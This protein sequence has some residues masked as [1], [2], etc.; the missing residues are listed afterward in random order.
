MNFLRVNMSSKKITT[1]EASEKYRLLGNRGLIAQLSF[2]EIDPKCDPLGPNNKL[3]IATS[4]LDGFGITCAGRL[5]V[6]GKSP[7]TGG[8]KEANAGGVA[9]TKLVR[10]GIKAIIVEG[11]SQN[12]EL[13]I[14]H[15]HKGG[16]QL[17]PAKVIAGKGTYSVAEKVYEEYGLGAGLI[18]I[19]PAGEYRLASAG[20]FINDTEGEPS[21][22]AARGGMGAVMGTK[23]LKAIV[24]EDDGTYKPPVFNEKALSEARKAFS[25]GIIEEPAIKVYTEYGTMG[26]LMSLNALSGLPT[27]NFRKGT[28]E[29]AEEI[30]GDRFHDLILERG[31]EGKI[32]HKCMPICVIQCSNVFPDANGKKL[33]APLEFEC[34]GLLGSNLGIADLDQIARLTKMCND[35]GVDAIEVGAALGVAADAGLFEFADGKRAEELIG[36]IG[37]GTPLGRILGSGATVTGKVF[38]VLRVPA[39]KGQ[40]M[41]AHDPRGIKGMS[42]TY[43]MSPMGADHT[44]AATYRAQIDHHKPEG[45]MEVSRNVQVIMAFYDNCCCMFVS[46][47]LIKKPELF[48]NLINAIYGTNYGTDYLMELGK[49][50]IKLERAFNLAAGVT[51]EYLPEFMKIEKLEPHGLTSDIPQSDYDRFWEEAFWG[52]FPELK[53]G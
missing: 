45:Q 37:R 4:P 9:A 35:I 51:Q 24:I 5:S 28:W 20:V 10:Q 15:I 31:G 27:L 32:T 52:K 47:G 39:V 40:A 42:V 13:Y 21:R 1:E 16:A 2:D 7:L 19:G 12:G 3:I 29:K 23:G 48:V 53:Q 25:K 11:M 49:E 36:E 14:L 18:T 43:S 6:G 26:M 38:G 22:P 17:E 41:A 34:A 46:R 30:S 50:I 44:A 8:I 33:I